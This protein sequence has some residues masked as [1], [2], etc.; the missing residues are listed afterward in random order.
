[1][2]IQYE[3]LATPNTVVLDGSR[4]CKIRERLQQGDRELNAALLRLT[5]QANRWLSEGPWT[6]TSKEQTP[7][8]GDKHDYLSQAP[9][10]WRSD[11]PDGLPY[12]RRDGQVNPESLQC[13]DKVN[14]AKVFQASYILALAWFYTGNEAYS[15]HATTILRTWFLDPMTRMNPHLNHAQV[16]PGANSGRAIGIIDFSQQYTSVLD[17]VSILAAGSSSW[18]ADDMNAF[19]SWNTEYLQWL[20][21][22]PFGIEES[23]EE[24]NHGT[25]AAM[26]KAG[27]SL[28]LDNRE[29]TISEVKIL[30]DR[31]G[32]EIGRDGSQAR[33]L[34]RTRSWHYSCFNLV[35]FTRAALIASKVGVD[36]WNSAGPAGQSVHK[37]VEFLLPY[38]T[39]SLPW[40]YPDIKF[41]PFAEYDVARASAESGGMQAKA[42]IDLL[43]KPPDDQDL[44]V[45]RPAPEQLDAVKI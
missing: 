30:R 35:A 19:R 24:N 41:L 29:T 26:Q 31:I 11:T 37:A 34:A 12:T 15:A 14:K 43:Q 44:W 27:V 36:L 16:I 42:A 40:Q 13:P 45:L 22:S 3:R 2:A 7:P 25:F 17:A 4:L 18:T 1:M 21:H 32:H 39:G 38:A 28:F 20:C 5:E 33:E 9:Y 10:W 23:R 8:S 6:V